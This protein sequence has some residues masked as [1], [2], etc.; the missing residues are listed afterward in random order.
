MLNI[1]NNSY[2][3]LFVVVDTNRDNGYITY[4]DVFTHKRIKVIDISMSST[5]KVNKK[6]TIY[7]YNRIITYDDISVGTGIHCMMTSD[8]KELM[9]F[10][11]KHKYKNCNDFSRCLQL[12]SISKKEKDLKVTCNN[13]Y[14]YNR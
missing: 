6:R 7:F 11:K 13:Q 9:N 3:G 12:Y 14:E 1:M 2:V 10:I 8:N 5:F 4:E